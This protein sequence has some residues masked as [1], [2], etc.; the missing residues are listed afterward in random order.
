MKDSGKHEIGV[1][2][3]EVGAVVPELVSYEAN[4]KDARSVDYGRL[5]ALLIEAVKTQQREI[6]ALRSDLRQTRASLRKIKSQ[7]T[8]VKTEKKPT[9]VRAHSVGIVAASIRQS[10][11]TGQDVNH[12][13]CSRDSSPCGG[14]STARLSE[15]MKAPRPCR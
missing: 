14:D 6:E 7:A 5:T 15:I 1:I 12:Y 9:T 4:G 13:G 11:S 2:A 3:E 10:T 8:V